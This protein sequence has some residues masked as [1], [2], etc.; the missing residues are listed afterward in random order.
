MIVSGGIDSHGKYLNEVKYMNL[1]L[2]RWFTLQTIQMDE[3]AFHTM[4]SIYKSD[5]IVF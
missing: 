3:I 2:H 4:T 1:I 5:M